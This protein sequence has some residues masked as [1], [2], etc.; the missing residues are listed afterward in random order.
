MARRP[1][2]KLVVNDRSRIGEISSGQMPAA[3]LAA[4]NDRAS[5]QAGLSTR[6]RPKGHTVRGAVK[7]FRPV[8]DAMLRNPDPSDWLMIR[9]NYR[10]WSYSPLTQITAANAKNL[11]LGW[12]WAMN[13]GGANQPTPI[14]HDGIIFL[15]NN[16]SHA[17]QPLDGRTGELIWEHGIGPESTRAYGATRG[18][19]E[20][21]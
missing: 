17:M 3:L 7:A 5:D 10:A 16:T 11:R 2:V 20:L 4:L 15:L 21:G 14:V 19:L 12:V 9:G 8:T 13:N 6:A 1:A 18:N